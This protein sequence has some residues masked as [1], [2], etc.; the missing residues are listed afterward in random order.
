MSTRPPLEVDTLRELLLAPAGPLARLEVVAETGSTNDAVVAGLR[1]EP[2]AWPHGSVLVAEH[3]TAG[4]GRAGRT[5]QTPARSAL[6]ATFVAR[7]RS[8]PATYGWLPLLA[9]L[10]T[11]RALRATAGVPAVLKWPNDVLVDLGD[12]V[13]QLAGWGG[14]RKVAGVLAQ[15]VPEVPA[16][17]VGIGVNVDQRADELPVPW[18]TSLALA[19]A[20]SADRGCLLVA[21]VTALDEVARRWSEHDGDA[22]AAGLLDEVASVCSTLG[23]RVRVELPGGA[24]LVGTATALAPDGALVVQDTD[25]AA[26][27]VLA[28]DVTHV[29]VT[30]AT[31]G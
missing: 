20:R 26:H 2:A 11:V 6:T 27:H 10:G 17:A 1:T 14:T 8:G 19:G 29:R 22:V 7:P 16:V 4:H 12:A 15:A 30:D 13:G 18:A 3:Q 31:A 5:W 25:G 21:L 28:G 24:D 23:R 9:G